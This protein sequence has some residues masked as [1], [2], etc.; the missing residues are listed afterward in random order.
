MQ[1]FN[2]F[3]IIFASQKVYKHALLL[4]LYVLRVDIMDTYPM[5]N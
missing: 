5:E 1:M 3:D 2:M 4:Y